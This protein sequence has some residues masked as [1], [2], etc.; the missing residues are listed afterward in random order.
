MFP[1]S[2]KTGIR[3]VNLFIRKRGD[4]TVFAGEP[5]TRRTEVAPGNWETVAGSNDISLEFTFG[6]FNSVKFVVITKRGQPRQPDTW[7][8]AD[9]PLSGEINEQGIGVL[10][11]PNGISIKCVG[12]DQKP[13]LD[14]TSGRIIGY[15]LLVEAWPPAELIKSLAVPRTRKVPAAPVAPKPTYTTEAGV[16]ATLAEEGGDA[17]EEDIPF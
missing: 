10:T 13:I 2:I 8:H 15:K 11:G 5:F 9:L 1:T 16:A 12:F 6:R 17:N 14:R 3:F 4:L 7:E